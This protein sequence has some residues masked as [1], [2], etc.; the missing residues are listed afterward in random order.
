MKALKSIGSFLI[1][2]K[3]GWVILA[4]IWAAIFF[5]IDNLVEGDWAYYT[6]MLGIVFN[7]ILTIIFIIFAWI[8]NPIREY[9]ER[10]KNKL[11]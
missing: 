11:Q 10:K 1:G 8:I 9:K 2:S 6:G 3:F 7:F 5:M 4:F